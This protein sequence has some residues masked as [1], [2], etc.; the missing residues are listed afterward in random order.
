[1][2][3]LGT[4]LSTP[5]STQAPPGTPL[6]TP[7]TAS[8]TT[9]SGLP[10]VRVVTAQSS[11]PPLSQ[12]AQVVAQQQLSL[13]SIPQIRVPSTSV[14]SKV[15][16]QVSNTCE[17]AQVL[18]IFLPGDLSITTEHR[19][20][21]VILHLWVAVAHSIIQCIKSKVSKYIT[22]LLVPAEKGNKYRR[23]LCK[24]LSP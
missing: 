8:H 10:Q 23:F 5:Q 13:A 6:S 15:F 3:Q 2:P 20:T 12:P 18:V 14:Q 24:N 9:S 19:F 22:P 1:M 11:L 7:R 21:S 4:L 17:W 16:S